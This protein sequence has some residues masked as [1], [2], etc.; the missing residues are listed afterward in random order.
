VKRLECVEDVSTGATEMTPEERAENAWDA[1]QSVG[2]FG[3]AE[4]DIGDLRAA[5]ADAIRDAVNEERERCAKFVS[6]GF[7]KDNVEKPWG[8]NSHAK[9]VDLFARML[10]VAIRSGE[11][12]TAPEPPK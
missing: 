4:F 10:L 9:A 3:A 2:D 5:I 11:P 8:A 7:L 1:V 12:W 6:E